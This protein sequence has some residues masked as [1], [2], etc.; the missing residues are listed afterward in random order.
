ML[1]PVKRN[2]RGCQW[3][4]GQHRANTWLLLISRFLAAICYLI[5]SRALTL[6]HWACVGGHIMNTWAFWHTS[7]VSLL[8][9]GLSWPLCLGQVPWPGVPIAL[10]KHT[11]GIRMS[12]HSF[13]HSVVQLII[14][15]PIS[16]PDCGLLHSRGC[17]S[18]GPVTI[19]SLSSYSIFVEWINEQTKLKW[20][21]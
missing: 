1:S 12:R 15:Y 8:P 13:G 21:I 10:C 17:M 3:L 19:Q 4:E 20:R 6:I 2:G 5:L 9:G 14:C 18:P 7:C 11:M 16:S